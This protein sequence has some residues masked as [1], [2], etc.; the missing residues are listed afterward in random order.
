V[1]LAQS[2]SDIAGISLALNKTFQRQTLV[3]DPMYFA[4][5]SI[6][7]NVESLL[8]ILLGAVAFVRSLHAQTLQV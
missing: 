8:S 7:G 2:Q 3:W 5:H 4:A 6:V 1:T